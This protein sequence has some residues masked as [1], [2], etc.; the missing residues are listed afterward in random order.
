MFFN[1]I[2][3]GREVGGWGCFVYKR[4]LPRV[5]M[6]IFRFTEGVAGNRVP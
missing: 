1:L 5:E 3:S 4:K 6:R 2:S